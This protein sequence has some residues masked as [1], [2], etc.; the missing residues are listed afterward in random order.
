MASP[1]LDETRSSEEARP[2]RVAT[3]ASHMGPNWRR[4]KADPR[5]FDV[6]DH[7]A[8]AAEARDLE[9]PYAVLEIH[10]NHQA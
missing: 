4:F 5:G 3:G 8:P 2:E 1:S 7:L 10:A 6:D 9:R